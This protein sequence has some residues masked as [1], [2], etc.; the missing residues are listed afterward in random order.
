MPAESYQY[1]A[2]AKNAN[3]G[4]A[5][6][7][8]YIRLSFG[9]RMDDGDSQRSAERGR[10]VQRTVQRTGTGTRCIRTIGFDSIPRSGKKV[11]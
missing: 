5:V 8:H 11:M 7:I 4:G 6:P 3:A 1:N 2:N 10:V 9:A